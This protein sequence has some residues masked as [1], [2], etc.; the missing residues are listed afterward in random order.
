LS[1][2][3][4]K[5]P[6]IKPD[7][8]WVEVAGGVILTLLPVALAARRQRQSDVDLSWQDYEA[9]VWQSFVASGAPII[10][11][12]ISESLYRHAELLTYT[13]RQRIADAFH[14]ALFAEQ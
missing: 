6:G 4:R 5:Y 2:L 12:Q 1:L 10:L 9:M 7:H 11:W 8:I 3:E 13:S 14:D